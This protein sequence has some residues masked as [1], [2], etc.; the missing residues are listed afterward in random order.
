LGV[1]LARF[2]LSKRVRAV[3]L[4]VML[5]AVAISLAACGRNGQPEL[6]PGP[7]FSAAPPP[8]AVAPVSSPGAPANG[9]PLTPEQAQAQAQK[10]GFDANGNPVAPTSE[11]K[12]FFLDFLLQ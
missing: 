2:R 3:A 1:I 9:G 10:T 4:P 8:P 11:R 12:S 7:I 5:G 6:P